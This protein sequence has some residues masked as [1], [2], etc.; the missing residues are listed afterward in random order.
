MINASIHGTEFVGSDAALQLIER[1]ATADDAKTKE[2]LENHILIFNVVANPD[3]RIDA[4]RFNSNGIDLNRD[5]ITQSQVETKH[6]VNLIKEWNPMVFLDLHGYIKGYGGETSP[7]LIEPCTPPHNP[8][9][10]YD[11]YSKWAMDQA[12]SMEGNMINNVP[13]H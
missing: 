7:G 10:E 3:G 9:Y 8:N 4:T 5:F 11:L 12:E 1:F 6:T 2:L 13:F